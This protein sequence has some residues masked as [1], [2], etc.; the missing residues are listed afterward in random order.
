MVP[1]SLTTQQLAKFRA[2]RDALKK[3]PLPEVGKW[4]SM[5]EDDIWLRVV[6]QV[7]V[8]VKEAPA[9]HLKAPEIR[10][11]LAFKRL[12][13]MKPLEAKKA[14][15][16]VLAT[17]GTRYVSPQR[18]EAAPKVTALMKNLEVFKS[19]EGGP[20]GV[21]KHLAGM[22]DSRERVRFLGKNFSYMKKKGA[23]DFLTTGLGMAT[24]VIAL[25]SR[26]MGIATRIVP[27][28]PAQVT[29]TNYDTIEAFLVEHVCVPLGIS[30]AQF[31]QLLFRNQEAIEGYLLHGAWV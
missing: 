8:V 11:S 30:A 26:V 3:T 21:V 27:G 10:A 13:A 31:D 24:D 25:D 18:P 29:A 6:S 22:A 4:K 19:Y 14:L 7:V 2:I 28:L 17:I 5:S 23:R 15:G 12:S 1:K 16:T 20:S 9:K